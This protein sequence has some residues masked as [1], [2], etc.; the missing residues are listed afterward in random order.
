MR[1]N[2]ILTH[3]IT[4]YQSIILICRYEFGS[5]YNVCLEFQLYTVYC[6]LYI[7]N[8]SF[9]SACISVAKEARKQAKGKGSHKRWTPQ[10]LLKTARLG[11][12]WQVAP[13]KSLQV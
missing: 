9:Q 10:G 5:I 8:N 1:T 6:I 4:N 11:C 7:S 3:G 12:N 13:N 2:Y